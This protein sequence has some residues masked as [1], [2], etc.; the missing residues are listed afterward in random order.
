MDNAGSF[1]KYHSI[2]DSESGTD[3]TLDQ[4]DFDSMQNSSQDLFDS[5]LL[6]SDENKDCGS[7]TSFTSEECCHDH[8]K[9]SD[10]NSNDTTVKLYRDLIDIAVTAKQSNVMSN[11]SNSETHCIVHTRRPESLVLPPMKRKINKEACFANEAKSDFTDDL[12][13]DR[14]L[15]VSDAEIFCSSHSLRCDEKQSFTP[16]QLEGKSNYMNSALKINT[17][18]TDEC[19]YASKKPVCKYVNSCIKKY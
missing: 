8:C 1:G 19:V 7:C 14:W 9:M 2:S 5:A 16:C 3:D 6:F 11:V 18:F 4:S 17:A 15:S 12:H 13:K 10:G